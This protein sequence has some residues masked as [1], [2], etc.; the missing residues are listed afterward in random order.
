MSQGVRRK[1]ID[2]R[3]ID[4]DQ[5]VSYTYRS[6]AISY[7]ARREARVHILLVYVG[8]TY[9]REEWFRVSILLQN[10]S[11]GT[12]TYS[13]FF[14]SMNFLFIYIIL[15]MKREKER[16]RVRQETY[17]NE[18]NKDHKRRLNGKSL[19]VHPFSLHYLYNIPISLY[20]KYI[21]KS[22]VLCNCNLL[23]RI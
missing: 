18:Y 13:V 1:E 9:A 8:T 10:T 21:I 6:L 20:I 22:I 7:C 3:K 12:I 14:H 2:Q 17:K 15:Y 11:Y 5:C 23:C 19:F 4:E 16:A